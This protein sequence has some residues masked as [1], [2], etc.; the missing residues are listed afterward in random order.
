[1]KIQYR[2]YLAAACLCLIPVFPARGE[3]MKPEAEIEAQNSTIRL[4]EKLLYQGDF[5]EIER[6]GVEMITKREKQ[7]FS[8]WRFRHLS[9]ALTHPKNLKD[10]AD[11]EFVIGEWETWQRESGSAFALT[12]LGKAYLNYGHHARGSDF[13]NAVPAENW[14]KF[15]ERVAKAVGILEKARKEDPKNPEVYRSLLHCGIFQGWPRKKMDKLV[16]ESIAV[17]P[18]YFDCHYNMAFY[19]MERWHG[20]KGDWQRYANSLPSRIEGE[21]AYLVYARLCE[22]MHPYYREDFFGEDRPDRVSWKK[23]KRGFEALSK[24]HPESSLILNSYAYFAWKAGDR[25]TARE[26][27]RLLDDG[28]LAFDSAWDG[29]DHLDAARKELGIEGGGK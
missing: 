11:W 21:D 14:P 7:P 16:K 5:K 1:M 19:L 9:D 3:M 25:D 27:L 6:V 10:P 26:K 13:A 22:R 18:D 8:P 29:R 17:A 23:M 15:E 12:L 20:G 24:R 4:G 28:G 2:R